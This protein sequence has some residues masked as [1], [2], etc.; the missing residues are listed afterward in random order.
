MNREKIPQQA[1]T[2]SKSMS[3]LVPRRKASVALGG[4]GVVV[5]S[6]EACR[7]RF[8]TNGQYLR[9]LA[10]DVLPGIIEGAV[11]GAGS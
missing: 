1:K 11:S 10:D 4:T 3:G 6:C 8:G 2:N 9:H 5:S 7:K